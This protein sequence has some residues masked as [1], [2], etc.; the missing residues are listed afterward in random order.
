MPF[1]IIEKEG[2][3]SH[4]RKR[5]EEP[6]RLESTF[7]SLSSRLLKRPK[8]R[9]RD[10]LLCASFT[11]FAVLSNPRKWTWFLLIDEKDVAA[12][13]LINSFRVR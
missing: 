3:Q 9:G 11:S 2:D 10:F 8:R 12:Q 7:S 5:F 13:R 1:G 4:Q 6:S